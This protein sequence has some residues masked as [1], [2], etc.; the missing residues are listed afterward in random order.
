MRHVVY[1]RIDCKAAASRRRQRV[2]PKT[3]RVGY[4]SCLCLQPSSFIQVLPCQALS[5]INAQGMLGSEL[6]ATYVF[7]ETRKL[8]VTVIATGSSLVFRDV[9]LGFFDL[10]HLTVS[11]MKLGWPG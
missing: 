4:S 8:A 10:W 1:S 2:S 9:Y 3:T 11:T 7:Q 6:V 5:P